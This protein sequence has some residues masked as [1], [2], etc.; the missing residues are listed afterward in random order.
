VLFDV[1]EGIDLSPLALV[2]SFVKMHV[3]R[4]GSLVGLF[5][6]FAWASPSQLDVAVRSPD[7]RLSVGGNFGHGDISALERRLF[8]VEQD[9]SIDFSLEDEVL[10]DG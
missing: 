8:N 1:S 10:F 6:F 7:D 3:S 9:F 4:Y 2:F 5:A